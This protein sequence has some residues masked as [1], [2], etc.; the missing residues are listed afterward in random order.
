MTVGVKV[1]WMEQLLLAARLLPQLLVCAKSPLAE[2]LESAIADVP[3][4][5]NVTV[6]ALLVVPTPWLLKI[7][8][9]V[10]ISRPV[11]RPVPE[12]V[13]TGTLPRASLL[14]ATPA[15]RWPPAVGLKTT[16]IAQLRPAARDCWQVLV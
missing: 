15:V 11:E 7:S 16:L 12:S 1:T 8:R 13:T 14:T 3:A 6:C 9:E 5:D 10:E 2:M 4:F